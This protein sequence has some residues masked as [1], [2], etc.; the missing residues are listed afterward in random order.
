MID[1]LY[2]T[3][4]QG[5]ALGLQSQLHSNAGEDGQGRADH[6]VRWDSPSWN[7]FKVAAYYTLDMV[8]L[9]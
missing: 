7:G 8:P 6:T 2:R 3:A 1:P 9:I 4:A 5:R